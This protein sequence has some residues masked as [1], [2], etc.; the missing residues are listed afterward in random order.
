MSHGFRDDIQ[1][2]QFVLRLGDER[3]AEETMHER[4]ALVVVFC[5]IAVRDPEGG[6]AS[7]DNISGFDDVACGLGRSRSAKRRA[8]SDSDSHTVLS[9]LTTAFHEGIEIQLTRSHTTL[10][11]LARITPRIGK[12][13]IAVTTSSAASHCFRASMRWP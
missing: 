11:R 2:T 10:G 13:L 7:E 4:E 8:R 9:E 5:R 1:I 3:L 12:R 6:I